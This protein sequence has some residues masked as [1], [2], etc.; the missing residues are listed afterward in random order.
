MAGSHVVNVDLLK[1][2]DTQSGEDRQPVCTLSWG[3]DFDAEVTDSSVKAELLH[4]TRSKG[5]VTARPMTG[6]AAARTSD[7]KPLAVPRSQSDVL[8]V[9]YVDVQQ[10]DACV[11][12]TPKGTI[13]LMD[14]GDN[15]M[16]AR[17]LASRYRGTTR[18]QPLDVACI[19]VT[20]G[21]S[22]H[23]AGF[24]KI[25]ESERETNAKKRLY[26]QPRRVYHNGLVRRPS[27]RPD[28]EAFGATVK[29]GG[30]TIITGLE[31]DLLAVDTAEMNENFAEWQATLKEYADRAKKN[32]QDPSE[33]RGRR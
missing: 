21:D 11:I 10:G 33:I 6:F 8:K 4:L 24:T 31:S 20:H 14:G 22:D 32:N 19:V 18:E 3:D 7:G 15:Q 13:A 9:N 16:F 23:L 25:L 29:R 17:Y 12:E 28:A 1:F 26:I 30:E 5:Q 2:W 27:K